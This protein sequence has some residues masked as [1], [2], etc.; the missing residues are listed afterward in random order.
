MCPKNEKG[1]K[2][3]YIKK[4]P[5]LRFIYFGLPDVEERRVEKEPFSML[6]KFKL[7]FLRNSPVKKEPDFRSSDFGLHKRA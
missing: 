4:Q 6:L 3:Q 1:K 5:N 2:R 7:Q